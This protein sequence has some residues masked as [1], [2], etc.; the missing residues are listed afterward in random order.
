MDTI[1]K[2]DA[3]HDDPKKLYQTLLN[4]WRQYEVA[5]LHYLQT[6]QKRTEWALDQQQRYE[7]DAVISY[8]GSP[9]TSL[10]T[11]WRKLRVRA[12]FE[13]DVMLY[14]F[15]RTMARNLRIKGVPAW[16]VAEQLGHRTGYQVT[17]L[18]TS[19]SPDYLNQAVKAIDDFFGELTCEL[20][21]KNLLE[22]LNDK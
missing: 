13:Q 16:E 4:A 12:D 19:H 18:Y 17:E 14:S 20:R 21:V 10:R 15:R 6:Q 9:I 22:I 7:T 1:V 8:D 2:I 3:S 11:A 5:K